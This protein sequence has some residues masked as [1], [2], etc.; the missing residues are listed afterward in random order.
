MTIL[1]AVLLIIQFSL[2]IVPPSGAF[3]G[4]NTADS[5]IENSDSPILS[6]DSGLLVNN[7]QNVLYQPFIMRQLMASEQWD[8]S[9]VVQSIH[10]KKYEYVMLHFNVANKEDWRTSRWSPNQI[11][12]IDE[13]YE[14]STQSGKYWIYVPEDSSTNNSPIEN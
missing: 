12:A 4:A 14:L 13:N 3:A 5:V 11:R 1:I 9:P 2:F 7:N 8:Q 6:E 10:D